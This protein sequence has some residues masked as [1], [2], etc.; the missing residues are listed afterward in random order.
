MNLDT[1][2][3]KE[4]EAISKLGVGKNMV[5]SIH[6]WLRAFGMLNDA[7]KVTDIAKGLFVEREM[8]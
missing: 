6:Y 5:R 2:I 1:S 4:T 3:F 7:E 8:G